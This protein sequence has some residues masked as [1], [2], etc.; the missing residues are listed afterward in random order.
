MYDTVCDPDLCR[1]RAAEARREAE[2]AAA[3]DIREQW[4]DLARHW[5]RLARQGRLPPARPATPRHPG[6]PPGNGAGKARAASNGRRAAHPSDDGPTP[7]EAARHIL[8]V[9]VAEFNR[10]PL[11]VLLVNTFERPFNAAPWRPADFDRGLDHA[12][13]QGWIEA[14]GPLLTLTDLGYAAT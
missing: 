3:H 10:R 11:D 13:R 5:D 9:F 8:R 7:E 12:Q 4:L 14:N 6:A 1:Q 2:G